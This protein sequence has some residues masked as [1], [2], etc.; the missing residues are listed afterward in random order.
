MDPFFARYFPH[1][2]L[3]IQD[4]HDEVHARLPQEGKVLDLG[5]GDLSE[6]APYRTARREIW[7]VDFQEHPELQHARWFRRMEPRGAIPFP[8][9]TFDVVACSWVLEHVARPVA[10]LRDVGRV[11]RPGGWFIAMTINGAH[12]VTWAKRLL[13]LLPHEFTQELVDRLYNRPHHDTF[14]THYRL[15]TPAQLRRCAATAHMEIARIVRSANQ[16]YFAFSKPLWQFAVRFDA[17][18][19]RLHPGLGRIY[20]VVT[21]RKPISLARPFLSSAA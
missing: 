5:C 15:N 13:S 2:R 8:S 3:A 6:L 10:F 12:Y 4:Y 1:D 16:G 7:G 17:L 14:P 19:E 9:E 18:L 11:L 21:L 20:M